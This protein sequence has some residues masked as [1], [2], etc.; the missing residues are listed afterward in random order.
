MLY[1]FEETPASGQATTEPPTYTLI[2]KSVGEPSD[3]LVHQYALSL[4]PLTVAR[5]TGVLYRKD[6]RC[7]PDGWNQYLVTVTYGRKEKN[8]TPV[9][10]YTF[11]FDTTGGVV[12]VKVA[13][14]HLASYPDDGDWHKGVIGVKAD[15]EAEGVD[16]VIPACKLTYNFRH[17][18]GTVD[19]AFAR[20]MSNATGYTNLNPFRDFP[21][22]ELLFMGAVGSDGSEAEATV[23]YQFVASAN[24]DDLT[25]GEIAGIVKDG[26]AYA[27]AEIKDEIESG[28]A[29]R[30][31]KRVHVERVYDPLDF[32]S[33]FGWS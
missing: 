19:E 21:A 31:A 8:N 5:P 7:D 23:G 24:K 26:H 28:E 29:V 2:Y 20:A 13:R 22:G 12:K 27:W 30:Q 33:V 25:M 32:A 6:V 3:F 11:D 4:S 17:P 1:S 10:S 16:I 14:E 9:G 18:E 15:G